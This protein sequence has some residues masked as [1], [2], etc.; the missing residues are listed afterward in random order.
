MARFPRTEA[1]IVALAQAMASGL[2]DNAATYPAPPVAPADLTALVSVY[3]TAKNAA[4]AAQAAAEDA[5]TSK[6]EALEDLADAMK[7]DIRYAENT[8]DFDD[9]KLKLIGWAG[10]KESTPLA[11]PG[12]ARLLEAPKQGEGWVFL[13]W[14]AP[15]DGGA[16]AAYKV[17]RR[18]RPAG[19][20]EDAATAVITEATLVEQP[21]GKE[22]EYS[23][24]AVNKA[25]EGEPSN[26]AMVV[27]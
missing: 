10:R 8:A 3:T 21:R 20:W 7:S 13:D 17:M 22:L 18:E 16:P 12:Q 19:P 2:T 1:E 24:V 14:K 9:D 6:D 23:I 11:P 15:I 27:L 25:G 26:T 5:T 4:I